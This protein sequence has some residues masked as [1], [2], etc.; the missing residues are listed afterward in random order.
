VNSHAHSSG[1]LDLGLLALAAVGLAAVVYVVA[2]AA[3]NRR[4]KRHWPAYRTVLWLAGLACIAVTL[5]GP[6]AERSH[7]EFPAHMLGHLLVGMLAPIP[8][9]LAAPV[10]LALRTLDVVP[11]RRLSRMLAS[12]PVRFLSHPIP[13][14]TI[15]VGSLWLLYTTPLS[16]AM[17]QDLLMH[18]LLLAHFLLAGYLFTASIIGVDPSP[19][20][21]GFRLRLGVLLLGIAGHSILAKHVYANPP[22]GAS[23]PDAELGGMLMYYGGDLVELVLITVFF[24]QWYRRTRTRALDTTAAVRPALGRT[25]S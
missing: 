5:V 20:R 12:G 3:E 14:A 6:L 18:Y 22:R 16:G 19:H 11:A 13:A 25:R 1:G 21:A 17:Q 24:S 15:N 9:V 7:T 2:A 23:V 10:T 4:G 8:L